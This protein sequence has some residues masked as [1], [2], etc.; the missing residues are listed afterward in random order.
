M[1]ISKTKLLMAVLVVALVV[2]ATAYAAHT[3]DDVGDA[4]YYSPAINW[5]A[6]NDITFGCGNNNFCT[7]QN[8]KREDNM[9]FTYRYDQ[10]VAQPA[11][12]ANAATAAQADADDNASDIN[13]I[14]NNIIDY[15]NPAIARNDTGGTPVT[16]LDI[17]ETSVEATGDGQIVF[18]IDRPYSV[19]GVN[20]ELLPVSVCYNLTGGAIV[21]HV[22]LVTQLGNGPQETFADS[23]DSTGGCSPLFPADGFVQGPVSYEMTLKDGGVAEIYSVIVW[24]THPDNMP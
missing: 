4:D 3:F 13:A 1:F 9:V 6:A 19:N 12:T 2:P 11:L 8:V 17:N 22:A 15:P 21:D 24:W 16:T 18:P 14:Q 5:G 7:G 10:N 20:W 23:A